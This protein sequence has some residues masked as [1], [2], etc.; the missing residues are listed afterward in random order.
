MLPVLD[1][2]RYAGALMRLQAIHEA[3]ERIVEQRTYHIFKVGS[4][5]SYACTPRLDKC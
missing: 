5:A 3:Q 4:K 1:T 2:E